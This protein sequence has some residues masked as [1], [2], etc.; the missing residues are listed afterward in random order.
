VSDCRWLEVRSDARQCAPGGGTISR[1]NADECIGD[2]EL[3]SVSLDGICPCAE[4]R[5]TQH[6]SSSIDWVVGTS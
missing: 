2:G 5:E 1:W 3:D 6:R 4:C